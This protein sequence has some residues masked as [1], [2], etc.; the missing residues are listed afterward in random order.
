[1]LLEQMCTDASSEDLMDLLPSEHAGVCL[2][3]RQFL[4]IVIGPFFKDADYATDLFLR[5]NFQAQ[6]DRVYSHQALSPTDEAW[7]VCF[8]VIV[9]LA[10]GRD[11]SAAQSNS[12]FFQ[13]FFQTLK[14][15]VNNPR[16][17]LTPRL[18]NV[19]ALALLVCVTSRL[20]IIL[21]LSMSLLLT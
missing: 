15:T 6:V 5:S 13:P 10:I 18:V 1:M 12:P 14:M 21:I 20:L 7:A 11:E 9:L 3:P 2:P 17:F 8:N 19:Q 4:N 16:V